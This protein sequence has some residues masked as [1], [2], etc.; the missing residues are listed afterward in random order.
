VLRLLQG[1][2]YRLDS[3]AA[4]AQVIGYERYSL[5]LKVEDMGNGYDGMVRPRA[6]EYRELLAK[7]HEYPQTTHDWR[8][9]AT[10]WY[11]RLSLGLVPLLFSGVGIGLG[12]TRGRTTQG[13]GLLITLGVVVVYYASLVYFSTLANDAWE[14]YWEHISWLPAHLITA[15]VVSMPN[16]IVGLIG[17]WGLKR[18][19]W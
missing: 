1:K 11:K 13:R 18:A 3:S 19:A 15:G 6:L 9:M 10:E 12:I 8:N 16:L 14:P 7:M 5:Y 4:T 2:I 17:Y